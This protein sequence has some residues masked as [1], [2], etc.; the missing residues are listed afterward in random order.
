[1]KSALATLLCS[2]LL[3]VLVLAAS[4]A[5][6]QQFN[7]DNYLSKPHGITTIILTTGERNTMMM[8]TF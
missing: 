6:A 4:P 3:T 1:M 7:S 5:L 2:V 8:T